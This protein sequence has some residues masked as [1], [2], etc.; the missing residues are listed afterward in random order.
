VRLQ[1][2]KHLLFAKGY[3]VFINTVASLG[4]KASFFV[5]NPTKIEN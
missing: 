5:E 1:N 2:P 3:G 4:Y